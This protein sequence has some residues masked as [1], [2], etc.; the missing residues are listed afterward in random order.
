MEQIAQAYFQMPEVSLLNLTHIEFNKQLSEELNILEDWI[1]NKR[2][3]CVTDNIINKKIS[4]D[5]KHI[6]QILENNTIIKQA[7]KKESLM[8]DILLMRNFLRAMKK[9]L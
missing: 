2:C 5:C 9:L 7:R 6:N 4:L 1:D 8:A 3:E